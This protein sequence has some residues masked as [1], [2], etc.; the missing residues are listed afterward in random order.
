LKQCRAVRAHATATRTV[1]TGQGDW[2]GS[3]SPLVRTLADSTSPAQRARSCV[4]LLFCRD[5]DLRVFG[6][7]A[8][9]LL[10]ADGTRQLV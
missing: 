7:S 3:V 9:A 10:A 1:L 2:A 6:A 4:A 8:L 5:D